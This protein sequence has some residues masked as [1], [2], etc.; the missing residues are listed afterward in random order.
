MSPDPQPHAVLIRACS[1]LSSGLEGSEGPEKSS[2]NREQSIFHH[3]SS[4]SSQARQREE[5]HSAL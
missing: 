5:H 2:L 3:L 4:A 1:S